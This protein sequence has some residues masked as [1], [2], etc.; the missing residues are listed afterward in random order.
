MTSG[1]VHPV[2]TQKDIPATPFP[3]HLPGDENTSFHPQ[4]DPTHINRMS[5]DK[6][7]CS[8]GLPAKGDPELDR[9]RLWTAQETLPRKRRGAEMSV[10]PHYSHSKQAKKENRKVRTPDSTNNTK[11]SVTANAHFC[12]VVFR[13]QLPR[14]L[15][16]N[17]Y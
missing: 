3:R 14:H 6:L 2:A 5:C 11:H 15:V 17:R 10:M 8:H 9:R 13:P 7:G 4:V 1:G 16:S 12:S